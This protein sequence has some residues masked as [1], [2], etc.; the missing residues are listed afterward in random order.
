[1]DDGTV[2]VLFRPFGLRWGDLSWQDAEQILE[3]ARKDAPKLPNYDCAFSMLIR[4]CET[5][6]AEKLPI[7]FG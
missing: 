2:A 5:A 6:V 7:S 4:A 1:M 3:E